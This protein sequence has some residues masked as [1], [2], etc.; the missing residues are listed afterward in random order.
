M[1]KALRRFAAV[2]WLLTLVTPLSWAQPV[3]R[4]SGVVRDETGGALSG[5]NITIRGACVPTPRTV[6]TDEHAAVR[7]P[8]VVPRPL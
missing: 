3:A 1:L 8:P 6:I 5:V 7:V 2:A 4:L